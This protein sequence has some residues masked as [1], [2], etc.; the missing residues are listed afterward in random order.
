MASN[1][2]VDVKISFFIEV[3]LRFIHPLDKCC[4]DQK[5]SCQCTLTVLGVDLV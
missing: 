2:A 3:I 4:M 1:K 5:L